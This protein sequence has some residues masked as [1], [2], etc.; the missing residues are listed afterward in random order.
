[1][2]VVVLVL[3][4]QVEHRVVGDNNLEVLEHIEVDTVVQQDI[5][6]LHIG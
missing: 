1:V 4:V 6:A 5:V 3:L 2:Q